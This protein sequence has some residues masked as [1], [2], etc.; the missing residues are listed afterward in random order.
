MTIKQMAQ[1]AVIAVL[2]ATPVTADAQLRADVA[3]QATKAFDDH[4]AGAKSSMTSDPATALSRATAALAAAPTGPTLEAPIRAAT[5]QW[6]QGEALLRLNRPADALAPLERA[7]AVVAERQPNSNLHG[8]LLMARAGAQADRGR[9]AEALAAFEAAHRL[10]QAANDRRGQALALQNIGAIYQDAGEYERVLQCYAEAAKVYPD[11]PELL[12]SAHNNRGNALKELHRYAEAETAFQ[13]ALAVSRE[14]ESPVLEA[15]IL[16]NLA[17]VLMKMGRLQLAETRLR[18]ADRIAE[19]D[20]AASEWRPFIW[21]VRAQVALRRGDLSRASD[22]IARTFRGV[23]LGS[24]DLVFRDFHRTAVEVYG[25][26]GDGAQAALHGRALRR[27]AA[28]S[29]AVSLAQ[30]GGR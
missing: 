19:R 11:E 13:N 1:A 24:S 26:T 17:A 22:M 20:P 23:D 14:L 16:T 8:R 3:S 30:N 10:F 12:V 21:G 4:V 15:R 7:L 27:M 25:R 6:L 18:Q 5:A 28:A 29:G 9:T 2:L